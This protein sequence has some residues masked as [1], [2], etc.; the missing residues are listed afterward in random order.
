MVPSSAP[1]APVPHGRD[2]IETA[3]PVAGVH[4]AERVADLQ[5]QRADAPVP[6][7]SRLTLNVDNANG[8]QDRITVDLRGQGV[9][10]Q[11]AT[12]A[13]SADAM[14]LKTAD[15]QDSLGRH[16]LET[17]S[18]RISAAGR[19]DGAPGDAQTFTRQDDARRESARDTQRDQAQARD[20]RQQ[21]EQRRQ[22]RARFLDYLNGT[23]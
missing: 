18:V 21:E 9:S 15:L 1:A 3:R 17:D 4:Q 6:T 10:T 20:E 14:R 19:P 5:Q 12:D 16:G 7:V 13:A 8:S 2:P 23:N 11:I 22:E